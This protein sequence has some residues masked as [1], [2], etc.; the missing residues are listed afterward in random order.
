M[1]G[2][3]G[4][5]D[6]LGFVKSFDIYKDAEDLSQHLLFTRIAHHTNSTQHN[7]KLK[8]VSNCWICEGW[9]EVEFRF[10]PPTK[11]NTKT[12]PVSLH[13]S[14]DQYKPELLALAPLEIQQDEIH[15]REAQKR[16]DQRFLSI[17]EASVS[18]TISNKSYQQKQ[19]S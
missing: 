10:V 17:D 14:C 9:S 11:V 13:L 19:E 12:V 1:E 16:R 8:A 2:N 3:E 15:K 4:T 7:Q 6:A 5:T 18:D